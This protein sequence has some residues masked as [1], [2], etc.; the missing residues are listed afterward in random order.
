[1]KKLLLWVGCA[2]TPSLAVA[3]QDS[4]SHDTPVTLN[5]VEVKAAKTI[6][7][8]DGIL[9]LPSEQQKAASPNGYS[10]LNKLSMPRI[11]V[12]EIMHTVSAAD[13]KGVQVRVN[14]TLTTMAD[15]LSLDARLVRSVEYDDHPGVRYGSDTGYV[16]NIRTRRPEQGYTVGADLTQTAKSRYGNDMAFAQWNYKKSQLGLT[17][18][19]GYNDYRHTR[20]GEDACYRLG[21]ETIRHVS[22][23]DSASR[24]RNFSNNIQ[25]KYN[26]ADSASYVFQASLTADLQ[27]S[28]T[29]RTFRRLVK[30]ER[31]ACMTMTTEREK[32]FSPVLDLYF[33]H[34]L[35]SHQSVTANVV[36]TS[37]ATNQQHTNNEGTRYA[38]GVDGNTWSLTSEAVY[39]NRLKPFTLSFGLNHLWK[40]TRNIYSGDTESA[41][42][43]HNS[44]WY[45]FSQLKG[46]WKQ[47]D[48][49][50]GLGVSNAQYRQG[51][52]D[53]D[54]WLF[55]PKATL[56]Y[57]FSQALSLTYDFEVS[58]HISQIAM[59]SDTRI[60]TNSME[61]TV[62]NPNI[63]PNSVTTHFVRLAYAKPKV[64]TQLY[65]EWRG[66]K[67]CNMACYER[68]AD[69]TFLYTQ[70]NQPHVN[71]FY[72]DSYTRWTLA[73]GRLEATFDC[74]LFRFFNRGDDYN[75]C[76]TTYNI[77]GSL[78]AYLG[79]WTLVAQA[80]NGW[81]FMEGET[82]N[83]QGMGNAL[84]CSYRWGNCQVA[85]VWYHPLEAHPKTS[86][87][88]LAS[89]YVS[90][91]KT[92]R[93]GDNGNQ[94]TLNFTWKLSRGQ[95]YKDIR[96]TMRNKD[97]QT[98][99]L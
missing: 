1:M 60:R 11:R 31:D 68:T 10:L 85:L 56:T 59:I 78:Q 3:Q 27:H 28:P 43:M 47:L 82:M 33:H 64:Y 63:D 15:L 46:Q 57:A 53:F 99:I 62:G 20:L 79:R 41:N 39:E 37:I 23:Q 50:A 12:D 71:M 67:N 22:R 88:R 2:L 24:S 32:S 18:D 76:L 34:T 17:Y 21:D 49:S 77:S 36:G 51:G 9:F 61:W 92:M 55:Q 54:Y 70:K 94:I 4:V 16:I 96:R 87:A 38:Y 84:Q 13:G 75:H 98:G 42:R 26:L 40:F 97:T 90:K 83:H 58:Q 73:E 65:T 86:H 72:V 95:K 81:K 19:F 5:E 6:R 35:G 52:H 44:N 7:H 48:Y 69:D 25:L 66:N 80:D 93:S 91:D 8:A 89:R 30:P 74:G 45:L 14:G 29:S